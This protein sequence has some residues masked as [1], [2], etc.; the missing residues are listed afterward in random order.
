MARN[1]TIESTTD[2]ADQVTEALGRTA[3]PP[4]AAPAT[5]ASPVADP[6]APVAN[7]PAPDAPTADGDAPAAPVADGDAPAAEG[8][9]ASNAGKALAAHRDRL[10]KRK[11]SIQG[12]ID[13]MVSRR[14]NARRDA[15]AEE[16]RIAK[17]REEAAALEQQ[18]TASKAPK[19]A[20]PPPADAAAA[21]ADPAPV[22]KDFDDFEK[23]VDA[24]ALWIARQEVAKNRRESQ[25]E[26]EAQQRAAQQQREQ[27]AAATAQQQVDAAHVE[28]VKAFEAQTKDFKAVM[29]A[30]SGLQVPFVAGEFLKRS[31]LGPQLMYHLALNPDDADRLAA[32]PPPEQHIAMVRLETRLELANQSG[33]T[34][35]AAPVTQA[36]PPPKPVGSGRQ[37]STVSPDELSYQ[38][39]KKLREQQTRRR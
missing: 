36:P 8:D 29:E 21:G 10:G 28:R 34:P 5:P 26:Q 1:L 32:M 33:P 15:E 24:K 27:E 2:T 4:P 9:A 38:D 37:A 13:E 3:D 19:A 11:A 17:L 7:P 12:E 30:A 35:A 25:A 20:T 16:A 18:I 6:P 31:P 39:Y 14:A 23:Y 22:L